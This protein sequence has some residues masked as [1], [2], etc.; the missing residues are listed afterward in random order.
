MMNE[1]QVKKR[2]KSRKRKLLMNQYNSNRKTYDE[3]RGKVK[4]F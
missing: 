3:N 4:L 2:E 1:F